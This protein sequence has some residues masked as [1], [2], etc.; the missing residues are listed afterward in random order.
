[1]ISFFDLRVLGFSPGTGS[2]R[3]I[4]YRNAFRSG[5]S[6]NCTVAPEIRFRSLVES[7]SW[8]PPPFPYFP[9]FPASFSLIPG[10]S[11]GHA[12]DLLLDRYFSWRERRIDLRSSLVLFPPPKKK[13]AS[14]AHP[15]SCMRRGSGNRRHGGREWRMDGKSTIKSR[16]DGICINFEKR[17]RRYD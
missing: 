12:N 11:N 10:F 6:V 2:I 5:V 8:P 17:K 16:I 13:S 7:F 4:N 3:V 14:L 1:M 9:R 15:A